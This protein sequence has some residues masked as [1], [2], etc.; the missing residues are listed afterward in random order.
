MRLYL[1]DINSHIFTQDHIPY[2]SNYLDMKK[3]KLTYIYCDSGILSTSNNKINFICY[4]DDETELVTINGHPAIIDT[5][6]QTK[7]ENIFQIPVPN[8]EVDIINYEYMMKSCKEVKFILEFSNDK[9]I[10]CYFESQ[11]NNSVLFVNKVV[12]LLDKLKLY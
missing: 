10:D 4:N 1:K 12:T 7:S 6:N 9:C 3:N 5:S 8:I 11:G 2:C